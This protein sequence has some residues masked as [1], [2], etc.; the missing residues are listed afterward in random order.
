MNSVEGTI[1]STLTERGPL[2]SA[3]LQ[4]LTGKSQPTLSRALQALGGQVIALGQGKT[5]RYGVPQTI[6]GLPAQQTLWWTDA[7]GVAEPWGVLSLLAGDVLHVGAKGIDLVTR[8]QLPWF[9]APLKL[10]GFLGRAWAV[11]LGL[12]RDPERWPLDQ[13]LYA[14]LHI[15]DAIGAVSLGEAAG[16]IVPEAPVDPAA[17]AAHY[18]T[19]AADVSATLPAGSSAGGEQSKFLTGLASGER[20]LVKFSPPRGTPFGERWHDLLHAEALAMEVLGEHGVAVAQT[21]VIES[22]R[23]TYLESTRFDR[24]GPHGLGRRHVVALDA[25]H[26][27]F[28][29]GA[30][31]SWPATCDALARQRRL[32]PTD[33]AAVRALYE[34]GQ[35]IGNPDMH[36]GNLSL[37]ADDPA[38]GRFALAPLYDMLPM[39]WR[40]DGFNGLQDYAPFEPPRGSPRGTRGAEAPSPT[41]VAVAFWGRAAQHAQLSRPLRRVANEMAGRLSA[42]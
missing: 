31:Q 7:R 3:A 36:F 24:L 25:I 22:S 19:L 10:Q 39:R 38:R 6:R 21:R 28:V 12:D 26:A 40:T 33:A 13:L 5:T 15:D 2:T 1:F 8:G 11:R 16:E 17:R 35:L 30:R 42:G 32:S 20:V 29:A 37:W 27:Q 41:S 18:D 34:F 9:L 23:R 4:T 14:A